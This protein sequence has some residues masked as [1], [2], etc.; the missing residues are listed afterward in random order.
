MLTSLANNEFNSISVR[1][2]VSLRLELGGV[3]SRQRVCH[4]GEEGK[5]SCSACFEELAWGRDA[6]VKE[7]VMGCEFM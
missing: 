2:T 7:L 5:Q 1:M 4:G 3:R 6:I